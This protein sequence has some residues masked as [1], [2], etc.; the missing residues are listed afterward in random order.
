[1]SEAVL[2][3]ENVGGFDDEQS[4]TL[5]KGISVVKAP[6]ATGKSSFVRALELLVLDRGMLK[7]KDHYM[8][9]YVQDPLSSAK[10]ELKLGEKRWQDPSAEDVR[11]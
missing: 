9:L 7:G 8:N 11:V 4:F 2:K 1:M 3:V 6:N 5:K 10:V